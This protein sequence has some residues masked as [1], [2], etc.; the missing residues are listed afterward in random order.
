[1]YYV[2]KYSGLLVIAIVCQ[3]KPVQMTPS[4]YNYYIYHYINLET[5]CIS[6]IRS[7][8]SNLLTVSND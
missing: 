1:M 3:D 6:F 8:V 2:R 7:L 4:I 5:V